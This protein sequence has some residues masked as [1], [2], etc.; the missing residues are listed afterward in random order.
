MDSSEKVLLYASLAHKNQK[1]IDPD[2]P[3][4]SHT[5]GVVLNIFEAS[6]IGKEEF[7]IDFAIKVAL[8]HDTIEDTDTTYED[9]K[10]EFGTRIADGVLALS[11]NRSL[12]E[13]DQMEDCIKR[14][15]KCEKEIAIV[16]LADRTFN[17]RDK[18]LTWSQERIK[19]YADE[20]IMILN[21]LG[22]A[23]KYLRHNLR[24][25]IKKYNQE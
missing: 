19:L 1:M 13:D 12:P 18:P 11:K 15:Q 20:S 10:K 23:S 14:I 22:Y 2:V 24:L 16:K 21:E 4:I 9:L 3:Y 17:V 25:R 5:F 8:L 7:D 6:Y